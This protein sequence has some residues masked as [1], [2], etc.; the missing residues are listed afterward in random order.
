MLD[1]KK[2]I[3]LENWKLAAILNRGGDV[4]MGEE[5][6]PGRDYP[7]GEEILGALGG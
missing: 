6:L 7:A 4:T 2:K 3:D 1:A 5:K